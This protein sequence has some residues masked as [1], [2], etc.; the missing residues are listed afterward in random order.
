[1]SRKIGAA[2]VMAA[3]LGT[4]LR[5]LTEVLPKPLIPIFGR[6]LMTFAFDHL[7]SVGVERFVVNTHHLPQAFE[8][9]FP[10]G[11]YQDCPVELVHEPV[12][13]ET[14]GGIK[15]AQP[16][17]EGGPFFVYSG[18]I[19]TDVDLQDLIDV[20]FA[21]GND[22][23]L[24]LRK[25][26]FRSGIRVV[27]GQISA[28][29]HESGTHDF[30]NVSVWNPGAFERLESGRAGS[31]VPVLER[32]IADG[33]R[34]GGVELAGG[35]WFNIGSRR[36]YLEVHGILDRGD[37]VPSCGLR[38]AG[39]TKI[40]PSANVANDAVVAGFSSIGAGVEVGARALLED[41]IVW[42][43]A[44]IASDA[45]LVRCIVFSGSAVGGN[46]IDRD[47]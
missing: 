26:G 10:D 47:L 1:M 38:N 8:A 39:F 45:K 9:A 33:G 25:T 46:L 19:L 27:G 14:G 43:G 12:R 4:R 30:A 7:A 35:E 21:A 15:N 20:H 3:G 5:P 36:E 40:H 28:L 44:K 24:A 34:I 18:D 6:P 17:L 13:L 41:C 31:F 16:F 32:W 37:W 29:R 2:F 22:V 11:Q 23:T 42:P